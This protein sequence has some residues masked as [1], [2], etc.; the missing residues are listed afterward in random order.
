ME[1]AATQAPA[2]QVSVRVQALPSVQDAPSCFGGFVQVPVSG[3][4]VP[5]SWHWSAALQATDPAPAHTPARHLSIKVHASA[6][7]QNLPSGAAGF[8]RLLERQHR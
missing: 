2:R 4:H 5:T 7:L 1:F 6:S 8:E 3:M